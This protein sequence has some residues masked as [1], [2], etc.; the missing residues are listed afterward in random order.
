MLVFGTQI[1]IVTAIFIGLEVLMLMFQLASYLYWPKDRNRGRFLLLLFLMLLYNITG[2]LFPDPQI[3]IPVNIQ[4]MVAYGSGFL[5]ASYFPFYFY[6][7]FDLESLRWHAL[8]GVPLFLFLPYIVFFVIDFA[9]NGNLEADLKYGMIVPFLYAMVLL[10]VMFREIQKKYKI[11]RDKKDYIEE[12][13]MYC[14]VSPWATLTF[15][16]FIEESQLIEV[17][18]TNTGISVISGLFITKSVR[19]ARQE[20][21]YKQNEPTIDGKNPEEFRANCL[22]FGL[23]KTEILIVQFIYRGLANKEIAD[24]MLISEETV[25]KHIQNMFRKTGVRNRAALIHRLQNHRHSKTPSKL[26]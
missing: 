23:T 18:C 19:E 1:H 25:K 17:L 8:F 4:L 14:A 21:E 22:S 15:F 6:K 16:G 2:G 9:I 24:Q 3:G 13:A 11:K 12:V 10:W 5:M 26:S 7:A 20:L